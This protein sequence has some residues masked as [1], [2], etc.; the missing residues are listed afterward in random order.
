MP[1][2]K[3]RRPNERIKCKYLDFQ[4]HAL[5]RREASITAT[6]E[7]LHR[8]EHYT[9]HR[10]FKRFHIEQAQGLQRQPSQGGE[11]LH[12]R[13]AERRHRRLDPDRPE[14]VLRMARHGAGLSREA[15]TSGAKP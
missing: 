8:F 4:R 9:C 13:E 12:W 14:A 2:P 10:D 7:A 6:A 11:C 3:S 1:S 5:G 15:G